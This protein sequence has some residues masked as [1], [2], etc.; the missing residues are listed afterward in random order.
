MSGPAGARYLSGHRANWHRIAVVTDVD[1]V[2]HLMG[3][4]GWMS[5][6]EVKLFAL[7]EFDEA[8]TWVAE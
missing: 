4:F 8:K 5:P 3:L 2:R 1:W 6:G 7:D